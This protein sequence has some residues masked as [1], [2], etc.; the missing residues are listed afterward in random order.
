MK[1]TTLRGQYYGTPVYLRFERN[2]DGLFVIYTYRDSSDGHIVYEHPHRIV[3]A[4]MQSIIGQS[5]PNELGG[6]LFSNLEQ[7]CD[8]QLKDFFCRMLT[9]NAD[10]CADKGKK[11]A[12]RQEGIARRINLQDLTLGAMIAA[13]CDMLLAGENGAVRSRETV[14]DDARTLNLLL[15]KEGTTPWREVTPD[16]CGKWLVTESKHMRHSV[17][18]LMKKILYPLC[19]IGAISDLLEWDVYDPEGE[20]HYRR[21]PK[22]CIREN[23]APTMLTYGQ[24]KKIFP[25]FDEKGEI[26]SSPDDVALVLMATLGLDVETV[27]GLNREDFGRL[28]D[29]PDRMCVNIY[30][31]FEREK[32]KC[33]G[34]TVPIDDE[35]GR[36]KLPLSKY[37]ALC[38]ES[39]LKNSKHKT[40]PLIPHPT[41]P[42]RRMSPIDLQR[43]IEKRVKSVGLALNFDFSKPIKTPELTLLKN[44]AERELRKAGAEEEELRFLK[45]VSGRLVS[46]KHY[47]DFYNESELNRL[48]AMQDRWLKRVFPTVQSALHSK[49]GPANR[50][51]TCKSNSVQ[52]RT[53]GRIEIDFPPDSSAQ[54]DL[55][56]ELS[57]LYG[58]SAEIIF[59]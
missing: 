56:L 28:T 34:K 52:N 41:N 8:K 37:A 30:K 21:S 54:G 57:A 45:G 33:R 59:I 39:L 23:V 46:A 5:N 10:F 22:N 58:L 18:R 53:K 12:N 11:V 55:E 4:V 16:K 15:E 13:D 48:G 7:I 40:G 32:K 38:I 43:S 3:S 44:T 14:E 49:T 42:Q 24:C 27:C 1:N 19:T 9:M 51:V 26:H 29:F 25:T 6:D 50:M 47:E 20:E 36:R 17:K 2:K 35:S 31:T